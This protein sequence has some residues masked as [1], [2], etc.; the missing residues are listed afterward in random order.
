MRSHSANFEKFEPS[1][2]SI[3]RHVWIDVLVSLT[4]KTHSKALVFQCILLAQLLLQSGVVGVSRFTLCW[5]L[6]FSNQNCVDSFNSCNVTVTI[7]QRWDHKFRETLHQE[8]QEYSQQSL[9]RWKG[10]MYNYSQKTGRRET[11]NYEC[12]QKLI[13]QKHSGIACADSVDEQ[14]QK[15]QCIAAIWFWGRGFASRQTDRQ[16]DKQTDTDT[17]TDTQ[18]HTHLDSVW[19]AHF[20]FPDEAILFGLSLGKQSSPLN[21]DLCFPSDSDSVFLRPSG[22]M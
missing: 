12:Q 11:G 6:F 19:H 14:R 5:Q 2:N 9:L 7:S 22:Q 10:A 13:M 17:D 4:V 3:S 8:T 21:S 18:T 15:V 1:T 16:T 20:I